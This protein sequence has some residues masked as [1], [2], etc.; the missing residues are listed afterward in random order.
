MVDTQNLEYILHI[1]Y[2]YY[3]KLTGAF[4]DLTLYQVFQ[5]SMCP[6]KGA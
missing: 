1:K 4:E 2:K 6:T 5:G 3:K